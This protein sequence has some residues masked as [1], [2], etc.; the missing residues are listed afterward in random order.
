MNRNVDTVMQEVPKSLA[1][2][3]S[4]TFLNLLTLLM[5]YETI[6]VLA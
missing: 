2:G 3:N 4:G 6:R 5:D 1:R